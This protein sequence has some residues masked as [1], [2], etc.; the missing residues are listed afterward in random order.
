MGV[1]TDAKRPEATPPTPTFDSSTIFSEQFTKLQETKSTDD[2][3]TP[4][5]DTKELKEGWVQGNG[6]PQEILKS[7][8]EPL[9]KFEAAAAALSDT[10]NPNLFTDSAPD[11]TSGAVTRT[12]GPGAGELA[13]FKQTFSKNGG[14]VEITPSE[15]WASENKF[16]FKSIKIDGDKISLVG[17]DGKEVPASPEARKILDDLFAKNVKGDFSLPGQ[18]DKGAWHMDAAGNRIVDGKVPG[19]P[20]GTKLTVNAPNSKQDVKYKGVY[21]PEGDPSKPNER[22]PGWSTEATGSKTK[23]FGFI[24][25]D[26]KTGGGKQPEITRK[27]GTKAAVEGI[28]YQRQDDPEKVPPIALVSDHLAGDG[29]E[30]V[31]SSDGS[32]TT[33]KPEAGVKSEKTYPKGSPVL[34]ERQLENNPDGFT[35]RTDLDPTKDPER[36]SSISTGT[37]FSRTDYA[38]GSRPDGLVSKE[39]NNDGSFRGERR[40]RKLAGGETER[41]ATSRNGNVETTSRSIEG[42]G[43]KVTQVASSD[44]TVKSEFDPPIDGIS[45]ADYKPGADPVLYRKGETKPLDPSVKADKD[46]IDK[47]KAN[48]PI[49]HEEKTADTTRKV[50]ADG[51][52]ETTDTKAGTTKTDYPDRT[53]TKFNTPLT[54]TPEQQYLEGVTEIVEGKGKDRGTTTYRKGTEQV[55]EVKRNADG[56]IL[57]EKYGGQEGSNKFTETKS[58]NPPTYRREY[59]DGPMKGTV[60]VLNQDKRLTERHSTATTDAGTVKTDVTYDPATGKERTKRVETRGK[61]NT[62][63][64]NENGQETKGKIITGAA[65]EKLLVANDGYVMGGEFKDGERK[66]SYS[67]SRDAEGNVTKLDFQLDGPPAK[68]VSFDK[69]QGGWKSNPPGESIPGLS[70][71]KPGDNGIIAGDIKV[72]NSGEMTFESNDKLTK[73]VKFANGSKELYDL[74]EYSKITEDAS[75]KPTGPKLHWDGYNWRAGGEMTTVG[76]GKIQITFPSEAGKPKT[77]VRDTNNGANGFEVKF[78]GPNGAQFKISDWNNGEMEKTAN[79]QT[80]KLYAT[81]NRTADG[82]MEYL[83]G[84]K[85]QNGVVDFTKYNAA[86]VATGEVPAAV[87]ANRDG[88][89]DAQFKDGSIV[90]TDR[91]GKFIGRQDKTGRNTTKAKYDANGK[92]KGYALPNGTEIAKGED[93]G[94]GKSKWTLKQQGK[95]DVQISGEYKDKGNGNFEIVG[96]KGEKVESNGRRSFKDEQNR[97]HVIDTRCQEFVMTK[98]GDTTK[99]PP[100]KPT[101]DLNGKAT[102]GDL[103]N[104]DNGNVGFDTG[105]PDKQLTVLNPDQSTSLVDRATGVERERV[106]AKQPG[107]ETAATIKRNERGLLTETVDAKGNKREFKYEPAGSATL[108]GVDTKDKSGKIIAADRAFDVGEGAQKRAILKPVEVKDG[109]VVDPKTEINGAAGV[110]VEG[111]QYN[112]T[113]GDRIESAKKDEGESKFQLSTS[114]VDGNTYTAKLSEGYGML[115]IDGPKAKVR[116]AGGKLFDASKPDGTPAIAELE[117]GSTPGSTQYRKADKTLAVLDNRTGEL[118]SVQEDRQRGLNPGSDPCL[119]ETAFKPIGPSSDTAPGA[120]ATDDQ[121]LL[122]KHP[123]LKQEDLDT[124]RGFAKMLNIP[125]QVLTP[126][127]LDKFISAARAG[128]VDVSAASLTK[129]AQDIQTNPAGMKQLE[130]L[131][132]NMNNPQLLAGLATD[133]AKVLEQLKINPSALPES[134]KPFV[135]EQFLKALGTAFMPAQ[136]PTG[137]SKGAPQPRPKCR[138][139]TCPTG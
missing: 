128:G 81:G 129:I 62:F 130:P 49:L 40:E 13:G 139:G 132:A 126:Q 113:T 67:L 94:N 133:P 96:D 23:G 125:E 31:L 103:V 52:V 34:R 45:R 82:R 119:E 131:L 27:D 51:K 41:T 29:S 58:G 10:N 60:D 136:R 73:E 5:A 6:V 97:Q 19:M 101:W 16:D 105:R 98:P 108:V 15:K 100:E 37:K 35:S 86:R 124:M 120:A 64:I 84:D 99:N 78:D 123:G 50:F 104:F 46:I 112:H 76:P 111:V 56:S 59:S 36:R 70:K 54:G 134:I 116:S 53:V 18:N 61:D 137:P 90:S 79:G 55:A 63:T 11:Q 9:A 43:K 20:D 69:V 14:P 47:F 110:K 25:F 65:G 109:V 122:A 28:V 83:Q 91:E 89:R 74:R 75:G 26:D 17:K 71:A 114:S 68:Q 22:K 121:G 42:N 4:A 107:D 80:I 127:N 102:Q 32:Y 39:V 21:P 24:D 93:L 12:F 106:F 87:K 72:G 33:S 117:A 118:R 92:L 135:K 57:S 44:G 85:G 115:S 38:A 95:A 3:T 8:K 48:P 7:L 138:G 1:E 30:T 66:G 88:T 77:V 2:K